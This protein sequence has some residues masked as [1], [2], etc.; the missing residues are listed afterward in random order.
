[1]FS[2]IWWSASTLL[3]VGYGDIYPVTT[4]GKFLG[5]LISFLGVGMVAI[6]TGIISAGFVEQYSVLKK[7]GE[8]ARNDDIHFV[9]MELAKSD[10]WTGKKISELGLPR[11]LMVA[12]II[13]S[14]QYL[15]PRGE[16]ILQAGDVLVVGAK[17]ARKAGQ[18]LNMKEV[19]LTKEHPWN[20]N[21]IRELD[22]SR[23]TFIVMVKRGGRTLLPSGSM[24]LAEGDKVYL[25][26]KKQTLM[27]AEDYQ[28]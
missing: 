13:R 24:V 10:S 22:I 25:Y 7:S 1:A 21:K 3:T 4:M 16:V 27:A 14:Q 19:V 20:G 5:I 12:L 26:S 8:M 2:G 15:I 6:P 18:T 11:D 17:A 23:Q 9:R 28:Y